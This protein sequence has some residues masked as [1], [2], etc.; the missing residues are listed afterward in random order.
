MKGFRFQHIKDPVIK[1]SNNNNILVIFDG[2]SRLSEVMVVVLPFVHEW[3]V[4]H[5]LV[6]VEFLTKSR[7]GEEVARELINGLSI[8][9]GIGSDLQIAGMRDRHQ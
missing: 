7:T 3:K 5:H 1:I 9:L 4:V 6:H 2:T 8:K